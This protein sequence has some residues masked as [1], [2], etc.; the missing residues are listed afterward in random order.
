MGQGKGDDNEAARAGG[1]AVDVALEETG[2]S[3]GTVTQAER[4]LGGTTTSSSCSRS[5]PGTHTS[6]GRA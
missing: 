6:L 3:P 1:R 2:W 4:W 5:T